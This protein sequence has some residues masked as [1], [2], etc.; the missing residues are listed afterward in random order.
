MTCNWK[1]IEGFPAGRKTSLI[2]FSP[3][4]NRITGRIISLVIVS[5]ATAF[6]LALIFSEGG[7]LLATEAWLVFHF[8]IILVPGIIWHRATGTLLRTP[9]RPRLEKT[10]AAAASTICT[11][12]HNRMI[13][14]EEQQELWELY[15]D[16]VSSATSKVSAESHALR[17]EDVERKLTILADKFDDY[18]V[19]KPSPSLT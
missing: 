11:F 15:C 9:D 18:I 16:T 3:D 6:A 17:E 12:E 1:D 10:F 4:Y 13:T 2:L 8:G 7:R 14:A 19:R 5:Y